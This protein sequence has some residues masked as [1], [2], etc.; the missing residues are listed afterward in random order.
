MGMSVVIVVMVVGVIMRGSA[1]QCGTVVVRALLHG[2]SL[3]ACHGARTAANQ[4]CYW[5][6]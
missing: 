3:R 1:A 5:A 2:N 6:V 4:G